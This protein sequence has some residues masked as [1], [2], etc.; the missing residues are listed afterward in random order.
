MTEPIND[1]G[2]IVNEREGEQPSYPS[3]DEARL[4]LRI[5]PSIFD[6]LAQAAT[7]HQHKSVE[8]YCIQKL[9]E[10]LTTKI[11]AASINSPSQLSGNGGIKKITGPQGG[12]VSRA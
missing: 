3:I 4:V 1:L 2:V 10:T 12:L 11:G 5:T 7:F 6:R 9:I 8:D